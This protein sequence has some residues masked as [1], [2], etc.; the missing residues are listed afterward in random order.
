MGKLLFQTFNTS[1]RL[2]THKMALTLAS[3][4]VP[5]F[6][7]IGN[8]CTHL[9][10]SWRVSTLLV[11]ADIQ[12]VCRRPRLRQSLP[13]PMASPVVLIF[14]ESGIRPASSRER[15]SSR[16]TATARLSSLMDG[17]RCW[18]LS[19]SLS[20]K[21][22]TRFSLAMVVPQSIRSRHCHRGS[23]Q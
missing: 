17:S 18:L 2:D 23:G 3:L 6:G 1:H 20:R 9:L 7:G 19:A 15:R 21:N 16:Y 13:L 22:S 12:T 8:V 5:A 14:S 10:Y 11:V 4:N